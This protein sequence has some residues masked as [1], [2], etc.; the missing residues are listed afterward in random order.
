M[1]TDMAWWRIF[2]PSAPEP[3]DFVKTYLREVAR[4]IPKEKRISELTFLAV[5]T[6]TTGLDPKSDYI[7]SYG[8]VFVKGNSI[9]LQQA[10]EMYLNAK[11]TSP[12]SI[13]VHELL[14]TLS[15]SSRE[16]LIRTFLKDA[17]N[18]VLVGHHLS[19]DLAMLKRAGR[20]YGL[21]KIENPVIDTLEL[22]IRLEL[23]KHRDPRMINYQEFSL[24]AMCQRYG[25]SLDDR[26]TAAG[27]AFATAQ[28][29]IKLLR[30]ASD[31]GIH[32]FGELMET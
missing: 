5:D 1:A 16:E 22:G 10:R 14:P 21:A 27:D 15:Y 6:E 9:P 31:K 2:S 11:K 24:D 17:S 18:H 32:F 29:L 3:R 25:V 12:E 23:G 13:K 30:K 19:F 20:D 8:S 4:P 28:L 7:L 26:H